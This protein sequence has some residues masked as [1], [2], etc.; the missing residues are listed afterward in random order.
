MRDSL[1]NPLAPTGARILTKTQVE[2]LADKL[3]TANL[4]FLDGTTTGIYI[5]CVTGDGTRTPGVSDHGDNIQIVD[6]SGRCS[7]LVV[8]YDDFAV[9]VVDDT[10]LVLQWRLHSALVASAGFEMATPRRWQD[11]IARITIYDQDARPQ[12]L[13]EWY[14]DYIDRQIAQDLENGELDL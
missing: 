5:E 11:T 7:N 8:S 13:D 1:T 6:S 14:T 3:M 10:M 12:S 9:R 2:T 4:G